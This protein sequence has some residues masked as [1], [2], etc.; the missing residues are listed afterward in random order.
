MTGAFEIGDTE[1]KLGI[2]LTTRISGK[3]ERRKIGMERDDLEENGRIKRLGGGSGSE[4]RKDGFVFPRRK[5][6]GENKQKLG[7]AKHMPE[8]GRR[9]R[10][11]NARSYVYAKVLSKRRLSH[12]PFPEDIG[13]YS[14][15]LIRGPYRRFCFLAAQ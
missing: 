8:F 7:S 6:S 14:I 12:R 9:S 1:R 4:G 3:F 15:I 13:I 10:R 5:A 11:A 2:T